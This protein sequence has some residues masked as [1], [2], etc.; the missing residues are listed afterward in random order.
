MTEPASFEVIP[1]GVGNFWSTIRYHTSLLLQA[2]DESILVDCP[3][4]FFRMCAEAGERAGRKIDPAEIN[5][6]VVTHLHGDHCNGLEGFGLWR[7]F[8][9]GNNVRPHIYTSNAAAG[10][11][12]DKLSVS[13]GEGSVPP[14]LETTKYEMVDFFQLHAYDMGES[15]EA[16]GVRFET[17]RTLHSIPCFALRCTFAGRKLGYSCDTSYDPELI[18]FLESCDLIFHECDEGIHTAQSDLEALPESVRKKMRLVHLDDG[19]A[20]SSKIEAAEEG[21]VYRV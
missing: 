12:W 8:V 9:A 14:D 21:K 19:F 13:M 2:G 4:P 7:K 1:L 5:H 10:R 11:L 16:G 20:G 15:F 17:R 3:E 18:A 6:V